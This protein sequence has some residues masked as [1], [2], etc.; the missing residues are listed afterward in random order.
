MI[1]SHSNTHGERRWDFTTSLDDK[2]SFTS[3]LGTYNGELCVNLRI[4]YWLRFVGNWLCGWASRCNMRRATATA[5][6]AGMLQCNVIFW[7][8]L[9]WKQTSQKLVL[10]P[11]C[12]HLNT[13][14]AIVY[15]CVCVF[16]KLF[17]KCVGVSLPT[18]KHMQILPV[19][20]PLQLL[21]EGRVFRLLRKKRSR[22]HTRGKKRE[23][24]I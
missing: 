11:A 20:F 1:V 5:A 10:R 19:L 22:C 15:V 12:V 14:L 23:E 8:C 18:T 21:N 6:A 13:R 9:I 2:V 7:K 3:L 16:C 4:L 17:L 24:Q